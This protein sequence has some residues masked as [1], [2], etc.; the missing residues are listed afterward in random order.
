MKYLNSLRVCILKFESEV[1]GGWVSRYDVSALHSVLF[2]SILLRYLGVC[3]QG[4]RS[5]NSLRVCVLRFES[6]YMEVCFLG[7]RSE[8]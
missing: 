1:F 8:L 4:V 7:M 2:P 5:V 6:W 3:V